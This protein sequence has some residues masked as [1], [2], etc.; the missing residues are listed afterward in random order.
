MLKGRRKGVAMFMVLATILIVVVL[1][2][3]A[4]TIVANQGRLTRHEVGRI[5]AYYAAQA[6]LEYTMMKIKVGDW[7]FS[8]AAERY[9]CFATVAAGAGQCITG[10]L[11]DTIPYDEGV[12]A[13]GAYRIE[14]E[15]CRDAGGPASCTSAPATPA[16]TRRLNAKVDY[17]Y[18]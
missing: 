8:G 6:G 3:V 11:T 14:V 18:Q 16:G 17:T 12:T 13:G 5:Q 9:Y 10:V 4:L 2:N 7:P 15:V 1:A